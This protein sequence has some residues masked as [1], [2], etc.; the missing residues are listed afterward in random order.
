MLVVPVGFAVHFASTALRWESSPSGYINH[1]PGFVTLF[2][3][4]PA[5][6]LSPPQ[7]KKLFADSSKFTRLE[8]PAL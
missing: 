1:L 5:S 8:S 2:T 4:D 7:M 6:L 3:F